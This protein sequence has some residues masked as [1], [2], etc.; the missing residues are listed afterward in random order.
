[1]KQSKKTSRLGLFALVSLLTLGFISVNARVA[2]APYVPGEPGI[3]LFKKKKTKNKKDESP[4]DTATK[5][6]AFEKLTKGAKVQKGLF[7]VYQNKENYYFEIPD[8]LLDRD[9]MIL[10]KLQKIPDL[11]GF[12]SRGVNYDEQLIRFELDKETHKLRMRRV[13]VEPLVPNNDAIRRSVMDNYLSPLVYNFK[14]EAFNKDSTSVLV[15][16][17]DLYNGAN[18]TLNNLFGDLNMGGTNKE[19][20]RILSI[21]AFPNNVIAF[22]ELSTK[23]NKKDLTIE[24]SSSIALLPRVP[25]V[26]R[27]DDPRIGYFRINRLAYSDKQQNVE[28]KQYIV[29]WKLE[30]RPEDR[31]AYLRGELVEPQKPILFRIDP[32]TPEKWRKYMIKGVNDWQIAFEKAGFKNAI[33]AEVLSDSLAIHADDVNTS[34]ITYAASVV[35]NAMGP[36]VRDPRSGEIIDADIIWYHNVIS[37]LKTWLTVQ[38]GASNPEA[39]LPEIPD[40]LMGDAI[41]NVVTHEVGHSLGLRHNMRASYAIKTDS[42]RSKTFTDRFGGTASSIMDYARFNYVAQPGDGVTRMSPQIGPYDLYAIEY[43]Y[44]WYGATDPEE[45]KGILSDF[46]SRHKGDLYAYCGE[47]SSTDAI[48]PRGQSED[49]GNDAIQSSAYGID[50][51][52]RIV[53]NILSWTRT[54]EKGQT[55]KE[56]ADLYAGVIGQW[57]LYIYHA[58]ANVGGIYLNNV[59][60]GDGEKGF[61]YVP[62]D[63]QKRSLQFI[64]D[65][66]LTYPAWLFDA[67]ISEYTYFGM[68]SLYGSNEISPLL[69]FKN[70]QYFILQNL[71]G[72]NRCLRMFDHETVRGKQSFTLLEMMNMLHRHIFGITERGGTPD[73]MQRNLQKMFVDILISG[74][75][76]DQTTD[77]RRLFT[78][79]DFPEFARPGCCEVG[80]NDEESPLGA[81]RSLLMYYSHTLRASDV[82]SVKRGELLGIRK[83][84]Q[85][86]SNVSDTMSR[87][88]YRD[89]LMRIE[90]A[91]ELN[92]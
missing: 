1:M 47:Q 77:T 36:S 22:S 83:L 7:T 50:N 42:L 34:I 52:K 8:S 67:P 54:G 39:R 45:E 26:A 88:H 49:L 5:V 91:L 90:T 32:A 29:R 55:Y 72:N 61:E 6:T 27:L 92:Q 79:A 41:R 81:P 85:T 2:P 59:V 12:L 53:P 75:H 37:L 78:T 57:N 56:A 46:I 4:K 87:N 13:Q 89:L 43:G 73:M 38:T 28:E 3:K 19:L 71:L 16:V 25:M 35:P 84:L 9:F 11:G 58:M 60:P 70:R 20:S 15:K 86:R 62:R 31:E 17:N 76:K 33:R 14:V 82:I 18:S 74:A 44:R 64:M 66:A 21:K 63:L 65:E 48:D 40:E 69:S 10:N 51:L 24:A 80:H 68:N 30:P 23:H